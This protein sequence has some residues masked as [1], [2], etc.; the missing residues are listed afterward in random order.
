MT[1]NL[2]LYATTTALV[3]ALVATGCSSSS[4]DPG[5]PDADATT[6]HAVAA[7]DPAEFCARWKDDV[8]PKDRAWQAAD[9]DGPVA[10]RGPAFDAY[11]DALTRADEVAPEAIRDA[12]QANLNFLAS[13]SRAHYE[14]YGWDLE[15]A[16]VDPDESAEYNA[17]LQSS[18]PD[19]QAVAQ[20]LQTTC[21]IDAADLGG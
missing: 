3:V 4:G 21:K 1:P 9:F 7:P 8:L 14:R 17:A 11:L 12:H 2:R 16:T 13:V 19:L 5:D 10:D 18:L 20:Y 15:P 6:D